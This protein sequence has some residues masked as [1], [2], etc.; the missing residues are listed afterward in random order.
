MKKKI[1]QT[2]LLFFLLPQSLLFPS[3]II[4]STSYSWDNLKLDFSKGKQKTIEKI[5]HGNLTTYRTNSSS[6]MYGTLKYIIQK[7]DFSISGG[8]KL[9]NSVRYLFSSAKTGNSLVA[10]ENCFYFNTED[11][12]FIGTL[13]LSSDFFS[14]RVRLYY[15]PENISSV[16]AKFKILT[17][18][19][20][21]SFEI[22]LIILSTYFSNPPY[23]DEDLFHVGG[24]PYLRAYSQ[25]F[26][27]TYKFIYLQSGIKVELPPPD[28]FIYSY[29]EVG[30][31]FTN[32]TL[33]DM[34]L[35]LMMFFYGPTTARIGL[36]FNNQHLRPYFNIT[37]GE[38]K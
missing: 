11:Q 32:H 33:W 16:G 8:I 9:E 29:G 31:N 22:P 30:Y 27:V 18:I 5:F 12:F 14:G 23:L 28:S 1:L 6:L 19:K 35:E 20:R 2:L 21:S 36:A 3:G 13:L 26:E 24:Y 4:L 10:I 17:S 38:E 7:N 25:D 34:G 37:I 15:H